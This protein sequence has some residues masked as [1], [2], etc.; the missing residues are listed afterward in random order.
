MM[1]SA[2]I[3]AGI[4]VIVGAANIDIIITNGNHHLLCIWYLVCVESFTDVLI[5]IIITMSLIFQAPCSYRICPFAGVSE[6]TECCPGGG[7]FKMWFT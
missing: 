7:T 2:I 3:I 5:F 4:F 6:C 1:T